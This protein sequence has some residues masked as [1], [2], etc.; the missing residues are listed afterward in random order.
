MKIGVDGASLSVV[1]ERLKVGV[2]RVIYNL[3]CEL[4]ELDITNQ[5][6]IYSFDPIDNSV[7]REFGSRMTNEILWPKKGWSSLRLPLELHLHPVDI[8]LGTAQTMPISKSYNIGFIYDLA[9]LHCPD[10]YPG[11]LRKLTEQT[12]QLVN[13][14]KHII[15][16]SKTSKADIE[17]TYGYPEES[18]TVAYPGHGDEFTPKGK[19]HVGK[20]PYFLFVGALKPGKN[21]PTLL[22]AFFEFL[23]QTQKP[24]DL[25]I[26]GGDYWRDT[27]IDELLKNE[28]L[29]KYIKLV[30]YVPDDTLPQYYRGAKA[31]IS[32]SLYEGFCLPAVEAMACGCPAIGATTG[33][34]PEIIGNS[35]LLV[36]PQDPHAIAGAMEKIAN[37]KILQKSLSQKG[38]IR[39]QTYSWNT[40][41]KTVLSII[42]HAPINP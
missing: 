21:V 29:A 17:K 25:Y 18:I 11:S 13:R 32:P 6:S 16:I 1:D 3:L 12:K 23:Q 39:A 5:Y 34:M 2:Y 27:K 28:E 10:A 8:F 9:F 15:T 22:H 35:G 38:I 4:G 40:L 41:A 14:S 20:N 24:Y 7:M 30:G 33:A 42:R 26:I 19:V 31:F 36:N 37:D